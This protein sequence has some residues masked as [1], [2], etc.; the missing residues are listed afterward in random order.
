MYVAGYTAYGTWQ[1]LHRHPTVYTPARPCYVYQCYTT[2]HI[3]CGLFLLEHRLRVVYEALSAAAHALSPSMPSSTPCA[4]CADRKIIVII[5]TSPRNTVLSFFSSGS[6][7]LD[8]ASSC[9]AA[10]LSTCETSATLTAGRLRAPLSRDCTRPRCA[11]TRTHCHRSAR[12]RPVAHQ[13]HALPSESAME[14][15]R[16]S[17]SCVVRL[18]ASCTCPQANM[19]P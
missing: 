3:L 15:T 18:H 19:R 12:P 11:V 5:R 7:Y 14:V 13:M 2:I 8:G 9:C 17:R 4:G 16:A 6:S 1:P 10:S